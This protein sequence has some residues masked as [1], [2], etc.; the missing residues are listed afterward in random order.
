M[1][2]VHTSS[3]EWDGRDCDGPAVLHALRQ[4]ERAPAAEGRIPMQATVLNL[5]LY[6]PRDGGTGP[7]WARVAARIAAVHPA[8]VIVLRAAPGDE[9]G[10]PPRLDAHITATFRGLGPGSAPPVLYSEVI[11]LKPRGDLALRWIDLLQ[12]LVMAD[13]PSS[14]CWLTVPPGPD[15]RWDLLATVVD[16]LITEADR[17]DPGSWVRMVSAARQ[18]R[19]E[20]DDLGWPALT[21]VR[22]AV[23]ELA[24]HDPVR[25]L[26]A[27][28][29]ATITVNPRLLGYTPTLWLVAW[30][31]SRLGWRARECLT[32][33][34]EP[35]PRLWFTCP[36]GEHTE[37]ERAVE[38]SRQ[39]EAPLLTIRDARRESLLTVTLEGH[40]VRAAAEWPG[41]SVPLVRRHDLPDDDTAGRIVR[42]LNVWHDP[43][44]TQAWEVFARLLGVHTEEEIV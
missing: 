9:H 20:V 25:V 42:M 27:S 34:P 30:L 3:V 19:M 22:L 4:A 41:L 31:A 23:A 13:L 11:D 5:I 2:N 15:F 8:R 12:P 14:L 7:D 33:D 17:D 39:A 36:A 10:A 43:I 44:F 18:H 6:V 16:H 29:G 32:L 1:T 40:T 35:A 21:P 26:L 24:D 28:P 38:F 37:E